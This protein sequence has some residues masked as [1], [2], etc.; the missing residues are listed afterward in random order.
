MNLR[1][2]FI[3]PHREIASTVRLS[4]NF[5]GVWQSVWEEDCTSLQLVT[6]LVSRSLSQKYCL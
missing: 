5:Q 2:G 1:I 6:A 4:D 3:V